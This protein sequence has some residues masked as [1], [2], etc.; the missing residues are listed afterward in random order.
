MNIP[1]KQVARSSSLRFKAGSP[2]WPVERKVCSHLGR[3][4]TYSS[5]VTDVAA[6]DYIPKSSEVISA[7]SG[8]AQGTVI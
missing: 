3:K 4:H 5:P 1:A 6:F 8:T 2:L 7:M